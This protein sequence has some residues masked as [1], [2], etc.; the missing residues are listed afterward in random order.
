M[1]ALMDHAVLNVENDEIMVSFYKG[2][3]FLGA[4]RLEEY[5]AGNVGFPSVRLKRTRSWISSPNEYG[6]GPSARARAAILSTTSVLRSIA[7][8]GMRS[9][10][11]SRRREFPSRRAPSHGGALTESACRS[12]SATAK[13]TSSKPVTTTAKTIRN[14]VC[15]RVRARA[16]PAGP[17]RAGV[18][19]V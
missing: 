14:G 6:K 11:G 18:N 12:T 10:N 9:W 19:G 16:Q 7:P 3:L 5:R 1:R 2:V 13:T 17:S 15:W 8:T 4:E